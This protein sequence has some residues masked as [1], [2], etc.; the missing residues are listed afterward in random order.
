[1]AEP[2]ENGRRHWRRWVRVVALVALIVL[3]VLNSGRMVLPAL[4]LIMVVALLAVRSRRLRGLTDSLAPPRWAT[5]ATALLLGT[6]S[7]VVLLV[8]PPDDSSDQ[9]WLVLL[10]AALWLAAAGIGLAV[11]TVLPTRLRMRW[12]LATL[13]LFLVLGV[14][15]ITVLSA[16]AFAGAAEDIDGNAF[17]GPLRA[18]LGVAIVML[19]AVPLVLYRTARAAALDAPLES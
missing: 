9:G 1:M 8:V 6:A 17:R 3:A 15:A 19:F 10:P 13:L 5:A 12:T 4:L 7:Y 18:V 16:G 11:T 14:L 2:A